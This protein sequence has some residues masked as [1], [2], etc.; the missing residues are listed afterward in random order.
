LRGGTGVCVAA[1]AD[2]AAFAP[3]AGLRLSGRCGGAPAP[4]A[5]RPETGD[6]CQMLLTAACV[7]G[8]PSIRSSFAAGRARIRLRRPSSVAKPA[9]RAACGRRWH[10]RGP[11]R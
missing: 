9:S 10:E 5:P 2:G 1:D 6:P 8:R 7:Q 3:C 4:A 11:Q